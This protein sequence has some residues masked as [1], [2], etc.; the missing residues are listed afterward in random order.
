MFRLFLAGATAYEDPV[1]DAT[2]ILVFNEALYY[3]DKLDH[4]LLNPN[5]IWSYG[6][7]F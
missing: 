6:I 3:G 4:S 1:S 2:Y 7:P 5:Q